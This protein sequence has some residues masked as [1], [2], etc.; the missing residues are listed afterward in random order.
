MV[1]SS[2]YATV[3]VYLAGLITNSTPDDHQIVGIQQRHRCLILISGDRSVD[4]RRRTDCTEVGI[5]PSEL[6]RIAG[7]ISI[8]VAMENHRKVAGVIH[9]D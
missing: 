2:K 8:V 9:R 3:T 1:L 7:T 6:H 4:D 5:V